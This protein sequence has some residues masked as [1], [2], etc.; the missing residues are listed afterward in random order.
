MQKLEELEK[1]RE[2]QEKRFAEAEAMRA[3]MQEEMA[4]EMAQYER[5]VRLYFPYYIEFVEILL[6]RQIHSTVFT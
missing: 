3:L 2:K 6:V 4:R 1:E 5:K